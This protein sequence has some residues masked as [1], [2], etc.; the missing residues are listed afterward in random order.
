MGDLPE[1]YDCESVLC[2]EP[3]TVDVSYPMGGGHARRRLCDEHA[4]IYRSYRDVSFLR[5]DDKAPDEDEGDTPD[6]MTKLRELVDYLRHAASAVGPPTDGSV[7]FEAVADYVDLIIHGD[8]D[9]LPWGVDE[10]Q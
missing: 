1:T 2:L 9:A 7:A 10:S 3:A 5:L 6:R 4:R 8:Y